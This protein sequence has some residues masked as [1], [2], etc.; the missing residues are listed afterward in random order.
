[1][2]PLRLLGRRAV[3]LACLRD[4]RVPLLLFYDLIG[5]IHHHKMNLMRL[6]SIRLL[7]CFGGRTGGRKFEG[8][9]SYDSYVQK[10][11]PS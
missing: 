5:C 10:G 6:Q 1:M 4:E 9:I 7:C 3:V 8:S 2:M 11:Y